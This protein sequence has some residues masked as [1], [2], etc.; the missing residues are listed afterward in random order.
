MEFSMNFQKKSK[1]SKKHSKCLE[2]DGKSVNS[3]TE[4]KTS[5]VGKK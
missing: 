5:K 1:L 2:M 4:I 3:G